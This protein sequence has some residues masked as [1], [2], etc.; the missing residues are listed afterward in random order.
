[1]EH[2]AAVRAGLY[3]T[4]PLAVLSVEM[5][6]EHIVDANDQMVPILYYTPD[7]AKKAELLEAW[8]KEKL[9]LFLAYV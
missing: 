5:V 2:Y 9:P 7:P 3:P 4:D 8:L 1:M 6:R